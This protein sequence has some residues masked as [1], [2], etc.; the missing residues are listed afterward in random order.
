MILVVVLIGTLYVFVPINFFSNTEKDTQKVDILNIKKYLSAIEYE[1]NI[2]LKCI[3][4]AKLCLVFVDGELLKEK[5]LEL[6]Q[7]I[8]DVYN[9]EKELYKK[10]FGYV[11]EDGFRNSRIDFEFTLDKEYRHD[12]FILEVDDKVYYFN[13]MFEKPKVYEYIN[14]VID[15]MQT[16]VDEIKNDF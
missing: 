10:E 12:D 15:E 3:D 11:D 13:P 14:E 7:N 8:P 2:S 5:S 4:D 9:Y 16:K 1:K 6:F